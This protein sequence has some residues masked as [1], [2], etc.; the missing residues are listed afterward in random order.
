[1]LAVALAIAASPLTPIGL[2]VASGAPSGDGRQRRGARR[3]FCGFGVRAHR[4]RVPR[5]DEC[6]ALP[7][8]APT[9]CRVAS[10]YRRHRKD[11]PARVRSGV[12][13]RCRHR[14]VE[15]VKLHRRVGIVAIALAT[16]AVVAAVTFDASLGRLV[17]SPKQ[18]GW[19]FDVVVGNT[20]DQSDQVARDAA[21]PRPQ[22]VRR[23]LLRRRYSAGDADDRR[24]QHRAGRH[25]RTQGFRRPVHA[26]RTVRARAE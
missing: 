1:M 12:G 19:T 2:A 22:S 26:R 4:V 8:V 25:R 6:D 16:A 24:S 9:R 14:V 15:G 10:R 11:R 13:P 18:Q 7:G 21:D 20:N 17:A 3:R 23:Q 5:C